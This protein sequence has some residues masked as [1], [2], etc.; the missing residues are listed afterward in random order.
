MKY[1]FVAP[2]L[3]PPTHETLEEHAYRAFKKV[4]HIL[5][6]EGATLRISVNKEG[7]EFVVMAEL[8]NSVNIVSKEKN[9]DMR[10]AID[11]VAMEVKNQLIKKKDKKGLRKMNEKI[12][13]LRDQLLN[14]NIE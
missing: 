1:L 9:R 14:R 13:G 4:E 5:N 7:E 8:W 10:F 6:N 12:K 3:T 2:S 11:G